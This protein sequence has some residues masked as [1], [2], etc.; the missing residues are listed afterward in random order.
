MAFLFLD[1]IVVVEIGKFCY[2][3]SFPHCHHRSMKMIRALQSKMMHSSLRVLRLESSLRCWMSSD[4][5]SFSH[6]DGIDGERKRGGPGRITIAPLI[7]FSNVDPNQGRLSERSSIVAGDRR[8]R[9]RGRPGRERKDLPEIPVRPTDSRLDVLL[10]AIERQNSFLVFNHFT[11][12]VSCEQDRR[13]L[14]REHCLAV[15]DILARSKSSKEK[16]LLH[17][18]SCMRQLGFESDDTPTYNHL[19]RFHWMKGHNDQARALLK[20]MGSKGIA[21]NTET[22]TA[23][24]EGAEGSLAFDRARNGLGLIQFLEE[25]GL[26]IDT[27]V[28]NLTLKLTIKR[29]DFETFA[30]LREGMIQAGIP[31]SQETLHILI[32]RH[33][34]AG[35][36]TKAQEAFD[37][38]EKKGFTYSPRMYASLMSGY[39]KAGNW[40]RLD[41]LYKDMVSRDVPSDI[42][43][44]SIRISAKTKAGQYEEAL[45]IYEESVREPGLQPDIVL[46]SDILHCHFHL[47]QIDRLMAAFNEL[48]SNAL[49]LP[50][51]VYILILDLLAKK[52]HL[53]ELHAIFDEYAEFQPKISADVWNTVLKACAKNMQIEAMESYWEKLLASSTVPNAK[54]FVVTLE[55]LASCHR[56]HQAVN[57]CQEMI[58]AKFEP[59]AHLFLQILEAC[60]VER[61]FKDATKVI[62]WMRQSLTSKTVKLQ[63]F[64]QK[65][66]G[67]FQDLMAS[68]GPGKGRVSRIEELKDEDPLS[69]EKEAPQQQS[70]V[71][72]LEASQKRK[73]ILDLYK[74]LLLAKVVPSLET[75]LLVMECQKEARD[76]VGVV[77]VWTTLKESGAPLTPQILNCLLVSA[78]E[79]GHARTARALLNMA[80]TE[81]VPLDSTSFEHLLTLAA[82]YGLESDIRY[83]IL[84]MLNAGY[85]LTPHLYHQIMNAFSVHKKIEAAKAIR[86]FVEENF[87]EAIQD[88]VIDQEESKYRQS[89]LSYHNG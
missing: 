62:G 69:H 55:A 14:T 29:K 42:Y 86:D 85:T 4:R 71:F 20:E 51:S 52:G 66:S 78:K 65:N 74:E 30:R 18:L 56:L 49:S 17:V 24:L 72:H 57:R 34:K 9:M 80:Q 35:D 47:D 1:L 82:S 19:I 16:E 13:G 25:Q 60:V 58:E 79:L 46:Y 37:E 61:K 27:N 32:H 2:V 44:V 76:L 10:K 84:D 81:K 77:K 45:K 3:R 68:L 48:S 15:L 5:N 26:K 36:L 83:T 28:Y 41:E 54:S 40:E 39:A 23:F 43:I 21:P 89:L 6:G 67:A 11:A 63:K 12:V 50:D 8:S 73:M 64:M 22:Y 33:V 88:E 87:P 53:T 59:P 75:F 38:V 70:L 7:P 31:D